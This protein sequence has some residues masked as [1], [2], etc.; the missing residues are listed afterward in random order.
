[1]ASI[2]VLAAAGL[3]LCALHTPDTVNPKAYD[4]DVV[5]RE[6]QFPR[7]SDGVRLFSRSLWDH[8][9]CA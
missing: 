6:D 4:L 3:P 7:I 8:L 5:R 1:M 2:A 9:L